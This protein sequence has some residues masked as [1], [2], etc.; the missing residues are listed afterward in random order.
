M[1]GETQKPE[2]PGAGS[3]SLTRARTRRSVGEQAI[4]VLL[5]GAAVLS[6]LTTTGIVV[7]L[8][9]ESSK[10]FGEIPVGDFFF[11]TDWA[12]LAGGDSTS[13]GVIPLIWS[14]LYLTL[15]AL[16]VA[17]P[18][19]LG[20]GVYLAEYASPRVRKIFKPIVEVLAGVPT[21]VFGFFALTF[22]TPDILRPLFGDGV[23]QSN[24]L[25]AGLLVGLLV[26]PT[27]AS[28]AEDALT[29]VPAS[30]REGSFGLGASR[31]TTS[32][33][34]VL[35]AA[36]S[37]VIAGLVLGASRA[38]G[39]TLVIL[40]AGGSGQLLPSTVGSA[41]QPS[42]SMASFIASTA[43]GDAATGSIAYKT[44]FAVGFT[45]FAICLVLNLVSIRLVNRYRQVYE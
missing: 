38:V 29:S 13:F 10:F 20:V 19:G 3:V 11:G 31:L 42:G 24:Q 14:T 17:V 5:A 34:V 32:L 45:L 27:I 7:T 18:L 22:L 12:P 37:G 35:P 9:N 15:I 4:K 25:A 39:E 6:V 1:R 21:I 40:L 33:R 8:L 30:L 16:I 23:S 36:L 43:T 26:L 2:R 44:I 41:T 28:I